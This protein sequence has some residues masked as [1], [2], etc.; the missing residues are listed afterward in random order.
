MPIFMKNNKMKKEITYILMF[1]LI[2][3]PSLTA[4]KSIKEAPKHIFMIG[5]DGLS[6]Y[7]LRHGADMPVLHNLMK[8]GAYSLQARTVLPSISAVNWASIFMG[9]G[10]ELHGYTTNNGKKLATG[11]APDLPSRVITENGIFP[12]IY[13]LIRKKKPTAKLGFM[14]KWWRMPHLVDTL[15]IDHVSNEVLTENNLTKKFDI[16]SYVTPA[17]EYIKKTKPNF[18]SFIFSQPDA[19]GHHKGWESDEYYQALRNIDAALG[20]IIA[21]IQEAAIMNESVIIITS[22]HGGIETRHGGITMKEMEAPIVYYGKGIKKGHEIQSSVMIYDVAA[23]IAYMF[24][25]DLPQVW[26]ARP[27]KEIFIDKIKKNEK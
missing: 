20:Y 15:S 17:T 26:I 21:A 27:T 1:F 16:K 8:Q 24:D 6:S 18:A 25:I 5:F 10:P 3:S 19:I 4:Q 22:D 12:D 11:Y 2:V 14:C 9:A 23:T 7:S 13:H